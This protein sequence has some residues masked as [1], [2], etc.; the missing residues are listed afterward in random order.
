M[1]VSRSLTHSPDYDGG[2]SLK[3]FQ[4]DKDFET[5][6][7]CITDLAGVNYEDFSAAVNI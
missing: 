4:F 5:E 6:R 2:E 7:D 1:Y 3:L